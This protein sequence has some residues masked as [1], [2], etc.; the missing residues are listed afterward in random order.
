MNKRIAFKIKSKK[1][2]EALFY[3]SMTDLTPAGI[4]FK[5]ELIHVDYSL[6]CT[7]ILCKLSHRITQ[8]A[9]YNSTRLCV[10][11]IGV[12]LTRKTFRLLIT[13]QNFS[14]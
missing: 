8:S 12:L 3:L 2:L 5:I 6:V 10:L 14:S 9:K 13:R 4:I 1:S 7:C 11:N